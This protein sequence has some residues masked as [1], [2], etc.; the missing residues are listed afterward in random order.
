MK[1][2]SCGAEITKHTKI[3]DNCGFDI[4]SFNK[5][6][7]VV[8]KEDP[9]VDESQKSGLVD[10]PILAFI[11]GIL[12]VIASF[13]FVVSPTIV[14]LYFVLLVLFNIL[15]FKMASKPARVKYEP[16]ANAGKIF[17]YISIG[18]VVFKIIFDVMSILIK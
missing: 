4:E 12:S 10:S 11:F 6:Q 17:A 16:F 13:A 2:K 5:L 1:C 14:V 15:A 3:C 8:V 18:F 9:V 7:R